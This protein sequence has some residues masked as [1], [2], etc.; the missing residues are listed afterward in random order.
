MFYCKSAEWLINAPPLD[1]LGIIGAVGAEC[2]FSHDKNQQ[3]QIYFD[4]FM[5]IR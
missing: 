2:Y 1:Q 4:T 3:I 5:T